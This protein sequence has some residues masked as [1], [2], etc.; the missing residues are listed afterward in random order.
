[1]AEAQRTG[2]LSKVVP[3]KTASGVSQ[4]D[5]QL[6]VDKLLSASIS[7]NT[8][9]S[10]QSGLSSFHNFRSQFNHDSVWPPHFTQVVD[11]VSYLS[12][13]GQAWSTVRSYVS[14][15]SFHCMV[16]NLEDVTKNFLS[17]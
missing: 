3:R 14:E 9:L 10:Y 11:Y 6:Q 7:T 16:Q 4:L 17:F 1:M 8:R 5:L 15:I 2:A 12:C 13:I